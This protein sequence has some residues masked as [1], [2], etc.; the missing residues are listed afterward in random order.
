LLRHSRNRV[1]GARRSRRREE[2]DRRGLT[3]AA[4]GAWK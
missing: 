3:V 2:E 4:E 1:A